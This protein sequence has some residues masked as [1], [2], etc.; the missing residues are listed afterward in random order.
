MRDT[1]GRTLH[2]VRHSRWT[3]VALV[4]TALS[5][6]G[7]FLGRSI[8]AN[9][10]RNTARSQ[11]ESAA[12]QTRALL[13]R[14][15]AYASGLGST[16]AGE[17]VPDRRR[18]ESLVGSATPTLGLADAMWVERVPAARR[19]EYERRLGAPITVPDGAQRAGAAVGY[20]PA[21]FVAGLPYR[22]GADARRLPA[23]AAT[24]AN[25]ASIFAGTAT[26]RERV[27]GQPGFFLVQEAQF[28]SGAGSQGLLAVFVPAGW[29]AV[30]P[31]GTRSPTRI[32]LDGRRI[33]GSP[34]TKPAASQSFEALTRRWT[35]AVTEPPLTTFEAVVP[36]FGLLWPAATALIAY[37]VARGVQRRRRAERDIDNIWDL[38][39]DPLCIL[40]M[41]GVV[42]RV[43]PALVDAS[44]Y[45]PDAFLA[46]RVREFAHPEDRARVGEAIDRAA[47]GDAP[48]AVVEAR[49]VRADGEV[50]WLT[51]SLRPVPESGLMYCVAH[52][53][54]AMRQFTEE[55]SALRRVAT[56]VARG[57]AAEELFAAVAAEVGELV[58]ADA[59]RLV[60]YEY[61]GTASVV[62]AHG[63][64]D[65]E[66]ALSSHALA[67]PGA[68]WRH[69]AE[70]GL[71]AAASA[72]ANS[73][74]PV[75]NGASGSAVASAFAAPILVAGHEWGVIV[76]AWRDATPSGLDIRARLEEFTEL[77][78]TAV[79][80]AESRTALAQS[81]LRVVAAADEARRRIER[82]LHDGAQQRLVEGVIALKLA[83][84][85]LA[86]GTPGAAELV[87]QALATTQNANEELREL[88][89][90]IHPAVLSRG[91]LD[92]ALSALAER[93]PIPVRLAVQTRGRLAESTEVTIYFMVSEALA[94][95]AKHSEASAMDVTVEGVGEE[96]RVSV[97]DD[98][99]GG[100][101]GAR[102]SGLVGLKD[103]IEAAGGTFAVSSPPGEGTRISA[104]L[105]VEPPAAD[106]AAPGSRSADEVS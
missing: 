87:D 22:P 56:L 58:R 18:F 57:A 73:G 93:S 68:A 60:R 27:A 15:G 83:R 64:S 96:V 34:G 102:G 3:A 11:A 94:N 67:D 7:F 80:N 5:V 52:D 59:T 89:R 4:V 12:D 40:D 97:C 91:G 48:G 85:K 101:D 81:R 30:S 36:L 53:I 19:A 47:A 23:L 51:W 66:M 25:P 26:E 55:Q 92:P 46:R 90:G 2:A 32:S 33:T 86:D 1:A 65:A 61:D 24:L 35:V 9:E 78:A 104:Q 20:L 82:D 103:R 29:L 41:Q 38:S 17:R 63:A 54:T 75:A 100:A 99:R 88:A 50:R 43:N 69:V 16:L 70:R 21:T 95:A 45:R 8:V 6:G 49:F 84:R 74:R 106:A 28:G 105:P 77:L 44:G 71:A 42:R 13:Q 14:A 62:A 39:L 37:L 31:S 98:G 10:R 72:D 79:A 76:V